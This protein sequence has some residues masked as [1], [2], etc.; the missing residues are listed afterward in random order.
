MPHAAVPAFDLQAHSFHSDGELRPREVV[1][2][3]ARAGVELFALTD[4][5]TVDGVDE[6]AAEAYRRDVRFL[7]ASE[8]SAVDPGHVDVHILGYGIDHRDHGLRI[9][10][11]GFRAD[12]E[13]R[14]L[15]MADALEANGLGLDRNVIEH[16]REAGKPIGRPHLAQAVL[17]FAANARRLRDEGLGDPSAV[18]EAYLIEGAPAFVPRTHPTVRE[19]IA[20]IHNAGGLAVWAH[21]FWDVHAGADVLATLRRY[22]DAGIDGVEAFYVTYSRTQTVLLL[23]AAQE[24][25]L[26]TT[27]SSDFH[28]PTH[29]LFHEFLAHDLHGHEPRLGAL[30][31]LAR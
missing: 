6:A 17:S 31:D 4:H 22:V 25:A 26:L 12:R 24:H 28:G 29:R 15:R 1:E 3:A 9:A 11:N 21:P 7:A 27:G 2:L 20:T 18:L 14:A 8:I 13:T 5:D 30:L 10:L 19:A 23:E 16:R